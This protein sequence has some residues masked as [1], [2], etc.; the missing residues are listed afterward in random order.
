MH[1]PIADGVTSNVCVCVCCYCSVETVN[2]SFPRVHS[3]QIPYASWRPCSCC[4]AFRINHTRTR[5]WLRF[6][7]FLWFSGEHIPR[8]STHLLRFTWN[9]TARTFGSMAHLATE[10]RKSQSVITT[11]LLILCINFSLN[12]I[13]LDPIK[14]RIHQFTRTRFPSFSMFCSWLAFV[15]CDVW[16]V[17]VQFIS[18]TKCKCQ[19]FHR[20]NFAWRIDVRIREYE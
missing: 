11:R 16:A 13:G 18:K 19:S 14:S 5:R 1:V 3:A 20:S 12:G 7:W 10:Q 15:G 8:T 9:F 6:T 4:S 17:S 2:Y